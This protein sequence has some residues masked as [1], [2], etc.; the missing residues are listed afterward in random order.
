[1]HLFGLVDLFPVETIPLNDLETTMGRFRV[2]YG[3]N[4]GRSI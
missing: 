2:Y 1:M 4:G 3:A